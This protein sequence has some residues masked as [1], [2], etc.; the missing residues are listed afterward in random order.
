MSQVFDKDGNGSINAAELR[1]V[2]TNLGERLNDEDM[3][4]LLKTVEVDN[5]GQLNYKG[6]FV[7]FIIKDEICDALSE[8]FT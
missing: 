3:D 5:D 8:I 4:E 7:I 6:G 1:H 2:M